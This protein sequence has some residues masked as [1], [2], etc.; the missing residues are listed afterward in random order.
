LS[1]AHGPLVPEKCVQR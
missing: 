1:N